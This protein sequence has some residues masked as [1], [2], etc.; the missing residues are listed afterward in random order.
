ME[1]IAQAGEWA[2]VYWCAI[3][4]GKLSDWFLPQGGATVGF[5]LVFFRGTRN[6]LGKRLNQSAE[7]NGRWHGYWSGGIDSILLYVRQTRSPSNASNWGRGDTLSDAC[8]VAVAIEMSLVDS[9]S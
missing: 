4:R 5:F 1:G 2:Q 6:S 3:R 8:M 9:S 7:K